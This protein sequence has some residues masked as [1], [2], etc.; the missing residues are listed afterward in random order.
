MKLAHAARKHT[1]VPGN[2]QVYDAILLSIWFFL[3]MLPRKGQEISSLPDIFEESYG[4]I[5]HSSSSFGDSIVNDVCS[6]EHKE[7]TIV[8]W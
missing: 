2:P 4:Y 3:N 7:N 1:N 5:Q 6:K 8:K